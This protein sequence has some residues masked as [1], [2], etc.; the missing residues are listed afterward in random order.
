MGNSR[1]CCDTALLRDSVS[2]VDYCPQCVS[3]EF[4]TQPLPPIA[5]GNDLDALL[6]RVKCVCKSSVLRCRSTR[7]AAVIQ[8][9]RGTVQLQLYIVL[10][11]FQPKAMPGRCHCCL[12][13]GDNCR[14]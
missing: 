4:D 9:F 5:D 1:G 8:R 6:A 7:A 2:T 3:T 14:Q 12:R 11:A 13:C 10:C